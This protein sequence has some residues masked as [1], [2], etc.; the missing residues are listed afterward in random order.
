MGAGPI[1]IL[2]VAITTVISPNLTDPVI[3]PKFLLI[4]VVT[5][6]LFIYTFKANELKRFNLGRLASWEFL[7]NNA[8]LVFATLFLSIHA[9]SSLVSQS[10]TTAVFGVSGRRNGFLTYLALFL[11]FLMARR[12]ANK[13]SLNGLFFSLSCV[14]GFEAIYMLIQKI[15]LDPAPWSFVY[16]NTMIGTLGNPDFASAF[17]ALSTPATG[18]LIYSNI[19]DKKKAAIFLG[20]FLIQITSLLVSKV[21]QG[22]MALAIAGFVAC[23]SLVWFTKRSLPYRVVVL[24]SVLLSGLVATLGVLGQGPLSI[25]FAKQSFQIRIHA[26]WETA[27]EMGLRNLFLGV[28]PDQFAD[29]FNRF[30]SLENRRVFG[31]IVTDNAHNY[32][33]Q[34]FAEIGIFGALFFLLLSLTTFAKAFRDLSHANASDLALKVAVISTLTVY[35][36]QALISIEHIAINIW[37]WILLGLL[38]GKT[39][40]AESTQELPK[41]GAKSQRMSS[42]TKVAKNQI[43]SVNKVIA[44]A[45]GIF[46][47]T[48]SS[49]LYNLDNKVWKIEQSFK[50]QQGSDLTQEDLSSLTRATQRWP[51]DAQLAT[52]A[53]SLLLTFGQDTGLETL[54]RA[55]RMSPE[56]SP[57]LTLLASYNEQKV[58]RGFGID[59]RE[60]L[61]ILQPHDEAN[62]VELIRDYLYINQLSKAEDLQRKL[63]TFATPATITSTDVIIKEYYS[64]Q[65]G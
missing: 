16:S 47:I 13:E 23:A 22:P 43:S 48:I 12:F 50:T 27:A 52:R 2:A 18:Y 57:A 9:L 59:S 38:S 6:P 15:G 53:S 30:Y 32:F 60:K 1:F 42:K 62:Y 4:L 19:K 34:F 37:F 39:L 26:Y 28:G 61:I 17:V 56:S 45:T 58:N 51:F 46:L 20:V 36:A 8:I 54:K 21:Y 24:S 41:N 44:T 10:P 29:Q 3:L 49:L 5:L 55:I 65:A 63:R 14:G 25:I 11:L 64:G 40:S 31:P 35:F 33:L 7:R